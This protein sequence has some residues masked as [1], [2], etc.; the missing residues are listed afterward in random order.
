MRKALVIRLLLV[1]GFSCG[2][3]AQSPG[4]LPAPK[5]TLRLARQTPIGA[6]LPGIYR[7]ATCADGTIAVVN[8]NGALVLVDTTGAAASITSHAAEL[9]NA[10]GIA[11][12]EQNRLYIAA[13]PALV[14]V[15]T[16]APRGEITLVNT[17]HVTGQRNRLLAVQSRLFVLG[18]ARVA[19]RFVFLL[20]Y[21]L[22]TGDP[23]G[24][25]D[26]D[27]S[28]SQAPP[29]NQFL[30]NGSLTWNP[31]LREVIYIPANPFQFWC[32]SPSGALLQVRQPNLTHHVNADISGL[33]ADSL[34]RGNAWDNMDW[35]Y[36]SA[37]FPDG[38][39]VVQL[40]KGV[41]QA[42]E[43]AAHLEVFDS[44]FTL[45]ADDV[46]SD[47]FSAPLIGAD[48]DGYLYFLQ[49]DRAAGATVFKARF[50]GQ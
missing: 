19:G 41:R 4:N 50:S 12:D 9:Q 37:S 39:M 25:I 36:G 7:S 23:V 42:G 33:P 43:P 45:I 27:L 29:F 49:L 11:C 15:Y 22:T 48:A 10:V 2:L 44:N 1:L 38:R 16:I 13:S 46:V 34:R 40:K 6:L 17:L 21:D 24:P 8:G 26:L 20:Q 14:R 47:A 30:L 35:I 31:V 18:L 28:L 3:G 5:G 32:I